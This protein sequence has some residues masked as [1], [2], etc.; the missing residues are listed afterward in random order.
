MNFTLCDLAKSLE[1]MARCNIVCFCKG[2][3][4]SKECRFQ[5]ELAQAYGLNVFEE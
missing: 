5:Y 1:Q 2:W 3:Q 4:D